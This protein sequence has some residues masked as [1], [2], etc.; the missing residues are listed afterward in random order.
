MK[1]ID[2]DL[3]A[4]YLT[5]R[6]AFLAELLERSD[7]ASVDAKE[8][9]RRGFIRGAM[10]MIDTL[11]I[12]IPDLELRD[13]RQP[14]TA[15]AAMALASNLTSKVR[16]RAFGGTA[17]SIEAATSVSPVKAKAHYLMIH[18]YLTTYGAMTDEELY[19]MIIDDGIVVSQSGLRARRSELAQAGWVR[20]TA[21][22]RPSKAG[23]P[24]IVWAAK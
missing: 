3:M 15:T 10:R 17:T 21:I 8:I 23:Y 19:A 9:E 20:E 22:K 6:K 4:A 7:A 16:V 11:E 18:Q 1:E 24:M 12:K 13:I 14:R 5:E 2:G